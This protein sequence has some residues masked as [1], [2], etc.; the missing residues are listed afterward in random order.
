MTTFR[1]SSQQGERA[2]PTLYRLVVGGYGDNPAEIFRDPRPCIIHC[3]MPSERVQRQIDLLL[4]S[5]EEAISKH[6]WQSVLESARSVLAVDPDNKDA[7]AYLAMA[8]GNLDAEHS[9]R[10]WA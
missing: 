8:Q 3:T 6:D 9:G 5:A 10:D 2:P 7:A 4:D 1:T